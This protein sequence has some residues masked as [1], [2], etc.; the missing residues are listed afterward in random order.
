MLLMEHEV[1]MKRHMLLLPFKVW[2][3]KC[4]FLE[5]L[6]NSPFLS[7]EVTLPFAMASSSLWLLWYVIDV[8]TDAFYI[9]KY[10]LF[11]LCLLIYMM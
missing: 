2:E 1:L 5:I 9:E 11:I 8:N 6:D 7:F 4:H 10:Y 3:N